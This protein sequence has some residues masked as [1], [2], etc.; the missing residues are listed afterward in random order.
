MKPQTQSPVP[1]RV[2]L[3]DES[4]DARQ[5]LRTVLERRGVEIYEADGADHGSSLIRKHNPDL[6]VLDVESQTEVDCEA[7]RAASKE[8]QS[9]LVV[10]GVFPRH[11]LEEEDERRVAKPYHFA[12]LVR[13]IQKLL[14]DLGESSTSTQ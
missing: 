3:V 10:L 5:V 12:P 4:S 1:Q 7:C 11:Q 9:S 8:T 2:L 14:D 13:T 6:V